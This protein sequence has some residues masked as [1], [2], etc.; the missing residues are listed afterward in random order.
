MNYAIIV[1]RQVGDGEDGSYFHPGD[2]NE[3]ELAKVDAFIDELIASPSFASYPTGIF[4]EGTRNFHSSTHKSVKLCRRRRE[5]ADT[6]QR[7]KDVPQGQPGRLDS[8]YHVHVSVPCLN[9]S[10]ITEWH[11]L[12]VRIGGGTSNSIWESDFLA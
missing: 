10:K 9:T 12:Q 1:R 7:L 8:A 6:N 11:K 2:F 3:K 5:V 4:E